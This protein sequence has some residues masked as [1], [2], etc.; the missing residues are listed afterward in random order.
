MDWRH[1]A[2]D[3]GD[4]LL[5]R[6]FKTLVFILAVLFLALKPSQAGAQV[7]AFPGAVG[8]GAL[9]TGGRG[10]TVYH[11][12]NLNDSGA[13]SF[14]DAVSAGNRIVVFDVGGYIALLSAVSVSSN[15]TLAGQT[16]PGGGIGIRAGE[17]SLS[18][19]SNI[20]I[21]NVR[22]RQGN[23]D[24]NTGR[25]ALNMGTGNNIILDHCSFEY[26][27][28]DSVDAVGTTNFTVQDCIIADPIGQQFG[29]H[30]EVGPDTFYRNLWVNAHNRQPLA[31]SNTQYINN[32]IYNYQAG[33]TTANTGGVFSHDIVGNYFI[34]GPSTTSPG[35]AYFQIGTNQSAYATGNYLDSNRDGVLNGSP[36]NTVGSAAVLAAPWAATTSS[37]PTLSMAPTSSCQTSA[38]TSVMESCGAF[39][40]DAVDNFVLGDVTSM[41]LTGT[42]YTNQA[43]TGLASNGYGTLAAGTPFADTS[44]DGI[45]DYWAQANGISTTNAAAGAAAYGTTGYTNLEAYVNSLVLPAPWAAADFPGT[46]IQGASSYNTFTNQWLLAGSGTASSSAIAQGQFASQPWNSDGTL[47]AQLLGL[48]GSTAEGGLM[49]RNTGSAGTA[50]VALVQGA[51][52]TLSL[53]WQSAGGSPQSAQ[54]A[55]AASPLYLKIVVSAGSYAGYY[56]TNG[57]TYTLLAS[58]SVS[59]GSGTQAGLVLASG[60][61]T[62]LGT[63]SFTNP[64]ISLQGCT[65]ATATPPG[66]TATFTSTWTHTLTPTPTAT[67][68][69]TGTNTITQTTTSTPTSSATSTP[70]ATRTPTL[71]ATATLTGT[72]SATPSATGT[73]TL[74]LSPTGTPTLSPTS[75]YSITATHSSTPTG[76]PTL[77]PTGTQP[78]TN[79]PTATAS[80]S[81]TSTP[82]SSLTPTGTPTFTVTL[83][84]S[85]TVT[86]PNT[87]TSSST[88]SGTPSETSTETLSPTNTLTATGTFTVSPTATSTASFTTTATLSSTKTPTPSSTPTFSF[89]RTP[90]P[91]GTSTATVSNTSS[92]TP[93]ATLPA[94]ST[95][96]AVNSPTQ[97]PFATMT[98]T[99]TL[100]AIPTS[101]QTVT[102]TPTAPPSVTSTPSG[103]TGVVIYPNPVTGPAV[104]VL[105]P[106]YQG[107]E[108]VHIE[109]F[110]ATF[111]KVQD[112]T[113]PNVPHG[114][115]VTV[116]LK[117]KWGAPLADGLYYIVV[118]VDGHRSIAKLLILR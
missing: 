55:Q 64:G 106:A 28:W 101:I 39:P 59:L 74:T 57:T 67:P 95:P 37:I 104:N 96:T 22:F 27:Q 69:N 78:P 54:V 66:L 76:T 118:I 81:A 88:P 40:R 98:S 25:S 35:N 91:T 94:T 13:G 107:I 42:I 115:A 45:A 44:G 2:G 65:T 31:K 103:N 10:G 93:T 21:R 38:Y 15:I 20:L 52:G 41:G 75:T 113:Y 97:T 92:H 8:F 111:R 63:A 73:M 50:Y 116:D 71:S 32:I 89:T 9:A 86:P 68:T 5:K 87:A 90:S 46:P 85:M 19:K 7:A 26:G 114:V 102:R 16:A 108:D 12:T 24:P 23:E 79:S 3:F 36:D 82:T 18:G 29:A 117:D 51:S 47:S 72:P 112:K 77:S 34:T 43:S 30:V 70:T 60:S 62:A 17:V 80:P 11:V 84:S 1:E 99:P 4:P 53:I 105:P 6:G 14:R 83:T 56:S 61:A 48:T 58:A 110:T 49:L 109:I 100:T 33:Y